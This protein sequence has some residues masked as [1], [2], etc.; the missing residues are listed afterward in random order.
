MWFIHLEML[1]S[2]VSLCVM[3]YNYHTRPRVS[4]VLWYANVEK[5][6][7]YLSN[8]C[9]SCYRTAYDDTVNQGRKNCKARNEARLFEAVRCS[10]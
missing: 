4:N 6:Y 9:C 2:V 3:V 10:I 8:H 1:F 5:T 7:P